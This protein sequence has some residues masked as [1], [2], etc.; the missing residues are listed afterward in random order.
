MTKLPSN[1]RK[2]ISELKESIQQS[3]ARTLL[4][5]NADML[6]LYWYI[7]KQLEEKIEKVSL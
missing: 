1:Y 7:G 3:Q 2:W 6:I 4:R 5:V